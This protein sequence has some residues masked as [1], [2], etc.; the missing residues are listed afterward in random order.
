[1]LL[2][3]VELCMLLSFLVASHF[4]PPCVAMSP[5]LVLGTQLELIWGVHQCSCVCMYWAKPLAGSLAAV[6][7]STNQS[8]L[9]VSG[10]Q[11]PLGRK[12]TFWPFWGFLVLWLSGSWWF[13]CHRSHLGHENQWRIQDFEK[14]VRI[15][16]CTKTGKNFCL[17]TPT[18]PVYLVCVCLHEK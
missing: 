17:T 13:L 12:E 15:I 14:G 2:L 8:L 5:P 16:R 4:R 6:S 1:M 10:V 11:F 3:C 18:F 9:G 7:T